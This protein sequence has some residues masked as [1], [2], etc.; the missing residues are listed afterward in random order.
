MHYNNEDYTI[1]LLPCFEQRQK[2]FSAFGEIAVKK[3]KGDLF[4]GLL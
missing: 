4:C 2:S 3:T 1:H